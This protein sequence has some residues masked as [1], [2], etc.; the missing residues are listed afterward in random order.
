[1]GELPSLIQLDE[2]TFGEGITSHALPKGFGIFIAIHGYEFDPGDAL[3]SEPLLHAGKEASPNP[4]A[5]K[6]A[7]DVKLTHEAVGAMLEERRMLVN[8]G[9]TVSDDAGIMLSHG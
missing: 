5:P 6:R 4:P 3:S 1:M 7:G 2:S 8:G 9:Q